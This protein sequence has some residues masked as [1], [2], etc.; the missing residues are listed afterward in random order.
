MLIY[1]QVQNCTLNSKDNR[2]AFRTAW[3]LGKSL[4]EITPSQGPRNLAG[5]TEKEDN[6]LPKNMEV[7]RG[8]EGEK[9]IVQ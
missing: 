7:G 6:D 9:D 3:S 1:L 2:Y 5:E 4:L 8:N